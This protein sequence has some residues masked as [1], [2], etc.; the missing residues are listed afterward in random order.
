[1]AQVLFS[2]DH[3]KN[4]IVQHNLFTG[5]DQLFQPEKTTALHVLSYHRIAILDTG[6]S[7][8]AFGDVD[9]VMHA[10]MP[11]TVVMAHAFEHSRRVVH[12]GDV[13]ELALSL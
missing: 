10:T 12:W 13:D 3:L 5:N 9:A 1:M 8:T 11:G 6:M 4:L 2:D 7:R